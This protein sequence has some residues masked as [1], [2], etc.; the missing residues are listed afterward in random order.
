MIEDVDQT[1]NFP[2][3]AFSPAEDDVKDEDQE[4]EVI[5]PIST[6]LSLTTPASSSPSLIKV[7]FC[8]PPSQVAD[9]YQKIKEKIEEWFITQG[10][11]LTQ[12]DEAPAV[13]TVINSS[14]VV[15]DIRRD[16]GRIK[17]E[18]NSIWS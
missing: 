11:I 16:F 9:L 15:S 13:V 1:L 17:G 2:G 14:R 5:T 7:N 4:A 6:T 10:L 3:R 12:C 8:A 18:K